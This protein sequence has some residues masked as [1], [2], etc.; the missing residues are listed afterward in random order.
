MLTTTFP[1]IDGTNY[2]VDPTARGLPGVLTEQI[3][4]A[5]QAEP[6]PGPA[7]WS[8]SRRNPRSPTWEADATAGRS[9]GDAASTSC[10]WTGPRLIAERTM[11]I[12]LNPFQPNVDWNDDNL[13]LI[14]LTGDGLADVLVTEDEVF[15]WYP[16]LGD[17]GFGPGER[18]RQPHDEERGARLVFA[19]GTQTIFLADMSGDGLTD[20]VRIRNGSVC[21]WPNVGYGRFGAKVAMDTAP[22][23]DRPDQFDPRRI[24]LA[25]VDG[26]GLPTSST[27]AAAK[28]ASG[29]TKPATG[30]APRIRFPTCRISIFKAAWRSRICSAT[31]PHASC[32]PLRSRPTRAGRF[33]I[34][35]SWEV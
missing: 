32:G 30:G 31:G 13:Q 10:I 15:T 7:K 6:R 25:D 34:S 33:A 9:D 12:T 19:D 5:L 2:Q 20:L 22:W 18:Q 27:S 26:S 16:S 28:S 23:L 3:R 4:V 8:W 17:A 21:Y 14:D 24:R 1:R 35:T 29:S 11:R